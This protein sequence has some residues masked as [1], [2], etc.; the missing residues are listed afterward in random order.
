VGELSP[1]IWWVSVNDRQFVYQYG[2]SDCLNLDVL[3]AATLYSFMKDNL[4]IL[5]YIM[6]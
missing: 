6:S 2:M 5:T 1:E 3:R 4:V